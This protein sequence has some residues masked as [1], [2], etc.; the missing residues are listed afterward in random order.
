[1]QEECIYGAEKSFLKGAQVVK[2]HVPRF[3]S[4]FHI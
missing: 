2:S 3:H 1:M 4:G